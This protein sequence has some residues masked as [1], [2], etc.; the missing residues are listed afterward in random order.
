MNSS[1]KEKM[2]VSMLGES[3]YIVDNTGFEEVYLTSG[4]SQ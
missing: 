1:R 3:S 4:E 2:G